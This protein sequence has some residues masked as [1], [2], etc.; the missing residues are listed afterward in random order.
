MS[1]VTGF[2]AFL[3]DTE[4]MV[5]RFLLLAACLGWAH[6]QSP[7]DSISFEP[8]AQ[9]LNF[10]T[11]VTHA[12]DGSGRLFI[13]E[14]RGRVL[15]H[16]GQSVLPSPFLDISGRVT[17]ST[18]LGDERGLL[19]IAFHPRFAANGFFFVHYSGSGGR[20]VISR[21]S[22]S[23]DPNAADPGS[24]V[25]FFSE[26]QPFGNHNGGQIEFGPDGYL[27][28]ADSALPELILQPREHIEN[29]GPYRVFRFR[30][31]FEGVPGQ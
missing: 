19:G 12:G 15:L 18:R 2:S 20:T 30:P 13:L 7:L 8:I 4:W 26:P 5:W 21:F 22:V 3:A 10:P 28:I 27:Y 24:E 1:N 17:S 16:D 9:N 11:Y 29:S 23:A 25:Q 31:G 14:R 6:A